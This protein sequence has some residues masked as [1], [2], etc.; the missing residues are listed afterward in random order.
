MKKLILAL[1][2][3]PALVVKA[4][5]TELPL[6]NGEVT[7][8]KVI[9]LSD[10]TKS[11]IHGYAR[12]WYD[13]Y[14]RN[15][16]TSTKKVD[17]ASAGQ[18]A[19]QSQKEASYKGMLGADKK[20]RIEYLVTILSKDGRA[21]I[22]LNGIKV[23]DPSIENGNYSTLSP[24]IDLVKTNEQAKSGKKEAVKIV[25]MVNTEMSNLFASIEKALTANNF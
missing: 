22:I 14:V 11:Q 21:K 9:I 19:I 15:W 2:L 5:N 10:A 12:A 1:L 7:F 16:L 23:I 8:E 25:D 20:M 24:V 18:F 17:D 3:I 13:T 6:V 4:Q